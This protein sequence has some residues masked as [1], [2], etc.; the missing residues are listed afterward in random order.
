MV[1]TADGLTSSCVVV[2]EGVPV[3]QG[4]EED[5]NKYAILQ[6]YSLNRISYILCIVVMI[7]IVRQLLRISSIV[8]KRHARANHGQWLMPSW[9]QYSESRLM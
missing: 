8:S 9:L 4:P 2:E 7:I 6:I 5:N 1:S 3:C